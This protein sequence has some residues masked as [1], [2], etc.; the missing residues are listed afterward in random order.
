MRARLRSRGG[1]GDI[2]TPGRQ[3]I[4]GGGVAVEHGGCAPAN[5]EAEAGCRAL[6]REIEMDRQA[7]A[8]NQDTGGND[9]GADARERSAVGGRSHPAAQYL[10]IGKDQRRGGLGSG[11]A[12]GGEQRIARLR[13]GGGNELKTPAVE[14]VILANLLQQAIAVHGQAGDGVGHGGE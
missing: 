8:G 10:G 13:R 11:E 7:V 4:A 5:F 14:V 9:A 6:V 2:G 3:G 1:E 12:I